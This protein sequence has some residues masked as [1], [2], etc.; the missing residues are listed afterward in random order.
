MDDDYHKYIYDAGARKIVGDF[1]AA[2]RNCGDVW[3]SQHQVDILKFRAVEQMARGRSP[4]ARILDI[5]AGYG[6]FVALLLAQGFEATGVEISPAAVRK[7]QERFGLEEGRLLIGDLKKGLPFPDHAFDVVVLF[8]V[9]WFLLDSLDFCLGEIHRLLPPDGVFA[10]S[11]SIPDDPIGKETLGNRE[12][13]IA[14][15][16][17]RFVVTE[18][19]LVYD[20]LDLQ[21]GLPLSA[22]K[23][24]M[25]AFCRPS[26]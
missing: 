9:F 12:D 22:C 17:R 6:D 21:A 15:L 24:D 11:I 25:V 7:G 10:V 1:D 14:I 8:G 3:P 4:Q 13:F 5:G 16:R 18:T 23:T 19:A 26:P 20:H 2:Y